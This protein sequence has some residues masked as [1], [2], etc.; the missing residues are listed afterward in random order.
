MRSVQRRLLSSLTAPEHP[1]N[2]CNARARRRSDFFTHAVAQS[3]GT[4]GT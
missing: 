2:L 3:R 4:T 1:R